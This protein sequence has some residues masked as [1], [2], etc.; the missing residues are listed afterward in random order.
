MHALLSVLLLLPAADASIEADVVI[1]GAKIIDGTGKA[2]VDGDLAIKG[3]RIVAVGTFKLANKP[4]VIDGKGLVVAPGFI[5][6]HTHSDDA[7]VEKTTRA[8]LNYLTQGVTT[9]V[10]GNCGFGPVDVADY[11]KKMEAGGVGSNVLHLVPHNSVRRRVMGNVNRGPSAAELKKMEALVEEGMKAGACGMSTGLIYD[12]GSYSETAELIA[13]AKAVSKYKGIYASH[14]RD[15][16]VG[17]VGATEE[18]IKIGRE[19]GVA[20]H[21]SH[22]KASGRKAWGKA[23]DQ[24]AVILKARKQGQV[25][26]ADQYPYTASSTSLDA[27]LIPPRYREGTKKEYRA[28]LD[29]EKTGPRIHKAIEEALKVRRDGEDVR[30][31][32]Y[33]PKPA[34]QGKSIAAIAKEEKKKPIEIVLEIER[35]GGAGI[36]NFGMSEEDVK[37]LMKQPFVATASDGSARVPDD[38]VPHPRSY[39]CFPRKIGHY[40]IEEGIVTLESAIRSSSGLPADVLHLPERGYLKSGYFADVVVFDPK[41]FRDKATYDK[42]HQ[43]ATGVRYLFVNGKQAIKDGKYTD[44]LAGK[45]IRHRPAKDEK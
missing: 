13:L 16:N 41:Q 4:Q 26:T 11:F 20:V 42:P 2:G 38:S 31:A 43:Y 18:A 22:I 5:D 9:I 28:R 19:A 35:N 3:D 27:T 6:L 30:I 34:W 14:I 23:A 1:R 40:A 24:I 33:K 37:I 12:P 21:V 29:D 7:M 15:E 17:V 36:V 44:A 10:T 45:V 8:N 39:G 32:R 25:V